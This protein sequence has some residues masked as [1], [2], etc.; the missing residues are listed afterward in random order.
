L[1]AIS[2]TASA[3]WTNPA[4]MKMR[5]E[6]FLFADFIDFLQKILLLFVVAEHNYRT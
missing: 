5:A 4:K 6:S 2:A 3:G 1:P